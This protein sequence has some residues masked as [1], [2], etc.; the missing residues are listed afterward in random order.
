MTASQKFGD[1]KAVVHYLKEKS[2]GK[3]IMVPLTSSLYVPGIMEDNEQV[4]V[5]VGAGYFVEKS[6]EKAKE[7]CDKKVKMLNENGGKV[8]EIIQVKKLQLQKIQIEYQKRIE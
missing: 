6:T 7:Y 3:E 2:K 1:S 4:L 5:E 8:A